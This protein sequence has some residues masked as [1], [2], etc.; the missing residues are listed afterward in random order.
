V[1]RQQD[2]NPKSFLPPKT[3]SL[4][5][6]LLENRGCL[7]NTKSATHVGAPFS[8]STLYFQNSNFEVGNPPIFKVYFPRAFINLGSIA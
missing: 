4:F 2:E 5:R 1:A 6:R 7:K 8:I 3:G